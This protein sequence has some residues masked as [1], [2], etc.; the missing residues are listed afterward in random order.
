MLGKAAGAV[1]TILRPA[2]AADE[3]AILTLLSENALVTADVDLTRQSFVVA[4]LDGHIEG[5]VGIEAFSPAVLLRSLAVRQRRRG[6]GLGTALFELAVATARAQRFET[7]FLLTTTATEF[8]A[9]HGL[10]EFNRSGVPEAMARSAQ[11]AHLCSSTAVCMT[12]RLQ[13]G[14]SAISTR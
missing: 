10:T 14:P 8:F 7:L 4:M 5:C 11:F 1:E 13:G 9:R 3:A 6:S 2:T 12:M